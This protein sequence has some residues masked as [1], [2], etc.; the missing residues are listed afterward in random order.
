MDGNGRRVDAAGAAGAGPR[1]KARGAG[2]F[3]LE[4]CRSDFLSGHIRCR[5]QGSRGLGSADAGDL[6]P[7]SGRALG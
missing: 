3:H 7:W 2:S 6:F 1:L 5:H 4:C